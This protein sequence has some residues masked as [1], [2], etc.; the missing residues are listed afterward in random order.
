MRAIFVRGDRGFFQN[1]ASAA[2]VGPTY[3][4]GE[5]LRSNQ[6]SQ[7]GVFFNSPS[8]GGTVYQVNEAGTG[9]TNF[10]LGQEPYASG[11]GS[12][13]FNVLP[14]GDGV[15]IY[16]STNLRAP[17]ERYV[18]TGTLNF[19]LTDSLNLS[20]DA[21]YGRVETTNRTAALASNFV[22]VTP[23]NPYVTAGLLPAL[24]IPTDFGFNI[25]LVNKNWDLQSDSYTRFTTRVRRASVGLD[26]RIGD[27]T[28]TWD[29][30]YQVGRT[31]RQQLVHD[32]LH[33]NAT[34]LA[35]NVATDP[36]TGQP[37]CAAKLDPSSQPLI[38]PRLIAACVPVNVFGTAPLSEAQHNYIFGDLD[39][40]LTY[41]QQ[42][43]A[44]N[45]SGVVFD[46]WGAGEI[47]A[48]V[49]YEHRD[50]LGKNLQPDLPFYVRTDYLIQYGEPFSGKV[51]VDEGYIETNIPL[52]KDAPAAK[53][54]ELDLAIRQSS[55][56]N[57]GLAGT[58]GLHRVH[59]L[60]TWKASGI[61]DVTDWW[62]FRGSQSRDARAGNFRELYYG[63]VI[64]AG[65]IFGYCGP[66]GSFQLDPC[67]WHLE[68]N[69][70]LSP[71]K[72]D[73]TTVGFVFSP[74]ERLSGLQL[75][76]DYFRIKIK[77]AIQQASVRDTLDGCLLR[78]DPQLC[79][80]INF[81]GSTYTFGGVTYPGITSFRALS[82]NGAGYAFKGLD[83]SGSYQ[84]AIR[85]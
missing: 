60:S 56:R 85:N 46:G 54:L 3:L 16:N 74:K 28:W 6:T 37:I 55:I 34:A 84:A 11:P 69:P 68:G 1:T 77:E 75:S 57:T 73:T 79:S 43:A 80:Q 12:S 83:F 39:E 9:L 42:V 29:G 31:N 64:G 5:N 65:G 15:P 47:R 32:N 67:D 70:D 17:V 25:G 49:G 78:N 14:G 30:Y 44:I 13:P 27:T 59:N 72:S 36:A 71:E 51:K 8:G 53:K 20:M 4:A 45:A 24:N 81:D 2:G 22:A 19:A 61:W 10:R 48:A 40:R 33:N 7:S 26:G 23:F 21:S 35:L 66:P 41:T 76:V 52:L 38:D 50:E 63:Q 62:R 82:F 58:T 18:A